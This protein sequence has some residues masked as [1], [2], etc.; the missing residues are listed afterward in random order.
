MKCMIEV[1]ER[2]NVKAMCSAL[3][4]MYDAHPVSTHAQTTQLARSLLLEVELE[5]KYTMPVISCA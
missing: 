2:S 1:K 5:F 3:K 4:T